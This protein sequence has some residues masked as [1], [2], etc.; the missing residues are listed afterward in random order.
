MYL[1][2]SIIILLAA[3]G[4]CVNAQAKLITCYGF[5][6]REYAGNVK[7]PLSNSC[8]D[9]KDECLSNRLCHK[10]NDGPGT[11]IRAPCAINPYDSGTCAQ[12][13]LYNETQI[14]PRV[15]ICRDGSLCCDNDPRC[16]ENGDGIFLDNKGFITDSAP[17]TTITWGP[18][19]TSSGFRV[20]TEQTS[21]TST[22]SVES[23]TSSSTSS[24]SS[25]ETSTVTGDSDSNK[26]ND[27]ETEKSNDDNSSLPIGLG[28]GL[29]VGIPL[30]AAAL[31][32]WFCISRKKRRNAAS[33]ATGTPH[34]QMPMA[35]QSIMGTPPP[36]SEA[37]KYKY[38]YAGRMPHEMMSPSASEMGRSELSNDQVPVEA[39]GRQIRPVELST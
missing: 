21:S 8:C 37:E 16:C 27:G 24:T 11:F 35:G 23:S 5:D 15:R 6:G 18:E 9:P 1:S 32:I 33:A 2:S 3:A 36:S 12:I 10:K 30:I 17:S 19:R 38:H 25:S 7:C 26:N 14:L 28:V 29:G 39:D 31:G 20:S 4:T 22:S 34:G 13:C